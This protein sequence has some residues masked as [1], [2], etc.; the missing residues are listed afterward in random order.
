MASDVSP[1]GE[2]LWQG[3][4]A[5]LG[6]LTC[7]QHGNGL[8]DDKLLH[9][10]PNFARGYT[11]QVPSAVSGTVLGKSKGANSTEPLH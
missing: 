8:K 1:T 2:E 6:E 11:A 4:R 7:D 10:N 9:T 3:V 5:P